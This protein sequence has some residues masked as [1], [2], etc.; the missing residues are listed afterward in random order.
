MSVFIVFSEHGCYDDFWRGIFAVC[1]TRAIAE[2]FIE[3]ETEKN[4][5]LDALTKKYNDAVVKWSE[6]NNHLYTFPSEPQLSDVIR[7]MRGKLCDNCKD[8][9]LSSIKFGTKRFVGEHSLNE[10]CQKCL[11]KEDN[12]VATKIHA[13]KKEEWRIQSRQVLDKFATDR[14]EF[15]KVFLAPYL[16][17]LNKYGIADVLNWYPHTYKSD[18]F[19]IEEYEVESD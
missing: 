1:A 11:S 9:K 17:I 12:K 8:L 16:E 3:K 18:E 14:G 6:E 19:V 10:I 5:Y 2:S 7:A 13:A 15:T 4:K